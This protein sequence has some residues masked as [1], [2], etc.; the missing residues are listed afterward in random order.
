M[1]SRPGSLN[2]FQWFI[3]VR[4]AFF[5]LRVTKKYFRIP[6]AGLLFAVVVILFSC[7][8]KK[9]T[10]TR[11]AYHNL[12]SHYNVYWNG[13]ES[14]KEGVTELNKK[15]KDNY[16]QVLPVF[17]Y[18]DKKDA[19]QINPQMD[20]AIKKASIA[21]QKHS[22]IFDGKER[23]KWIDDSYLLIG[24]AYFYK[25]EYISARRTFNFIIKEYGDNEIKYVAMLWLARTYLETDEFEKA[26]PLLNLI[27]KDA[28]DGKVSSEVTEE[29][30]QV[31]ADHYILQQKYDKAVDYLY[32]AISYNPK[33]D[34]KIR[35]MFILGQIF[36]KNG[37]L[38]RATGMYLQVIRKN[39]PY[40]MAFQAKINMAKSYDASAGDSR[41][42]I[43]I[44]N[45]MLKDDKNKDFKDQIYFALAEVALKDKNIPLAIDY[46]KLSVLKSKT[47]NYQKAT[48]ALQLADL[49]FAI[50]DYKKA[51]AYYDTTTQFLPK[52]YPNFKII[53][54]KTKILSDL[55]E[56][57]ITIQ[58]EDSL[59]MVAG[60]SE[61]DRN[62]VI[63]KIIDAYRA[64]QERIR[65]EKELQAIIAANQQAQPNQGGPGTPGI[66][67]GGKWYFYNE[68][69]K[70]F[71]YTAFVKKWGKRK[72]EDLWRLSNKQV[73][74]T[75][76]AEATPEGAD[77]TGS[78]TL[79]KASNDPLSREYY[80]KN[81]PFTKEAVT[82]SNA[83]ILEAYFKLGKLYYDGLKD[84]EESMK[85]FETM[86]NRF[87]DN[88][89]ELMSYYYLYKIALNSGNAERAALYKNLIITKYPDSDFAKVLGDPEYFTKK[90]AEENKVATLYSDTYKAYESGQYYMVIAKADLAFS[91]YGDTNRF[92]PKFAYLK[93]ISIGKIEVTDSLVAALKAI[94][95]K[96]PN[97][98]IKTLSQNV[99]SAIMNEN[100]QYVDESFVQPAQEAEIQSPYIYE[101]ALQHMF[102]IILDSKEV[103][104]NPLKVKI[105]DYNAKF[106]SIDNLTINSV[107]LDNTHYMVTVGNFNNA[108]KAMDYSDLISQSEYVYSDLKPESFENLV[109]ST[110]NYPTLF[111]EK[112]I[113][114]YKKFYDKNYLKNN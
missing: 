94:I 7:S 109:I 60:L 76:F 42:I 67:A 75:S 91:M 100:P 56:N 98:E 52:D 106:Y 47:N 6:S 8:T 70:E 37:D 4:N 105:S 2:R 103:K 27:S 97:S 104:L 113:E 26:E 49:Y 39:P 99:L 20:R 77:T 1:F 50:P 22:M 45:R 12:T 14:I 48:S 46:L 51:Q 79:I 82:S 25:H 23:V 57:L 112:K 55:V 9:N 101:P 16:S 92:A 54:A 35:M 30:P 11:R 32:E 85:S 44:L 29:L 68:S 107:V 89:H 34:L 19:Q 108:Q 36:Q 90:A 74:S 73:T 102:V 10:F 66:P 63:D 96:Y 17:N 62:V 21:I 15:L 33:R 87:P 88:L 5:R 80:M 41:E 111:K 3:I 95:I 65:K 13:K 28:S 114:D 58:V 24:E 71:G 64:E 86:N 53:Q 110:E 83:K 18:G 93:A 81:L 43:K 72:W 31:Y 61:A 84:D 38:N 78:D 69:T 40:E 59:Q